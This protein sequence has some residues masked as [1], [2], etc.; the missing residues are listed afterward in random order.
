MNEKPSQS[1]TNL[2]TALERLAEA[3]QEPIENKLAIDGTIQRFE[4][5]IELYWK[6]LKRLLAWQGIQTQTPREAL[7]RAYQAGWLADETA[8]LQMLR[9]R[10]QTS[11]LYNEAMARQI[12]EHIKQYFPE[13]ERTYQFLKQQFYEN[14]EDG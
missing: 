1:L 4:F 13:M 5:V 10:N 12:Y 6:T 11:H 14:Q 7:Q 3:L 8:W 9:D 2:E